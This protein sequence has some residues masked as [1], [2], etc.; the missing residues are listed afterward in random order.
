RRAWPS[1]STPR[2]ATWGSGWSGTRQDL[3][4]RPRWA[5]PAFAGPASLSFSTWLRLGFRAAPAES[6][7]QQGSAAAW[8]ERRQGLLA[9]PTPNGTK[10]LR[11]LIGVPRYSGQAEGAIRGTGHLSPPP[12]AGRPRRRGGPD[13]PAPSHPAD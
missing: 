11:A 10:A 7:G 12:P 5:A 6:A 4:D 9:S 8:T 2:P 1:P 13:R 3:S